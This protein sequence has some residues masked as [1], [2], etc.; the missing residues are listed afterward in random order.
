MKPV[1]TEKLLDIGIALSSEKDDDTLLE[2]ILTAAMDIT[3]CD[4]GTLYIRSGDTLVF[5][6]MVTRSLGIFRGGRR[7]PIELPPVQMTRANICSCAALENRLI[8]IADV[9]ED[10]L[11]DFSG[12]R[13]YDAMTGYRT[14]SMLVVPMENDDGEVIGVLQLLNAQDENGASIPFD[15]YYEQ[16][17]RSLASQAAICLANMN[18]AA[19][20]IE[21]LDSFV[22]VTSTAIDARSPYNANHTRNMVRYG[23][24]FLDWLE[25]NGSDWHFTGP[26]RRQFLMSV[27]LHDV[28][29]LVTPLEIMD[30]DSRLGPKLELVEH[31]F[32]T[33]GLLERIALLEGRTDRAE[34][35]RQQ[36]ELAAAR[37]LVQETNA[38]GLLTDEQVAALQALEAKT[39]LDEDGAARHFLAADELHSLSVRKGTL[40]PEERLIMESHVVMTAR[41]LGE[42]KFSRDCEMVPVWASEHHEYLDGS[43]YPKNLSDGAIPREVRLLTILDIFDALTARDRPY[44]PP[45]PTDRALSIL[46]S[47]AQAG[48]LDGGILKLF[49]ESHAW[50]ETQ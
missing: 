1:S 5:R 40:T 13:R 26:E 50:E 28:G 8:N 30:K 38:A 19:E 20:I 2:T 36:D 48:Q 41:M 46:D 49:E 23:G 9:Y 33:I 27:W 32:E 4:A 24:R 42:M 29:K 18:Y 34:F 7:G 15:P 35:D 25:Q 37:A 22:R 39:Y 43:G 6:I 31:R 14:R 21:L 12:P 44:K 3:S 10:E 11:F 17:I 47:M 16:V 45:M